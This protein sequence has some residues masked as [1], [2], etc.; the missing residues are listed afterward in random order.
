MREISYFSK[1]KLRNVSSSSLSLYFETHGPLD[2][3]SCPCWTP[4]SS[5]PVSS[6]VSG[7]IRCFISNT[8][9][10]FFSVC[11]EKNSP[12]RLGR[13]GP[14]NSRRM[15]I[16]ADCGHRRTARRTTT[17]GME[18][19]PSRCRT[20]VR[21]VLQ[22]QLFFPLCFMPLCPHGCWDNFI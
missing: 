6:S 2:T 16:S 1:I 22:I 5:S 8:V 14:K 9:A 11:S 10:L 12:H 19:P 21:V 4:L 7:I 18:T 13:S 20:L 17:L 15:G 3:Q